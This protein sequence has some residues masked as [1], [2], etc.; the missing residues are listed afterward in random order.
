MSELIYIWI[1]AH[2][3]WVFFIKIKPLP[4]IGFFLMHGILFW[5]L[6]INQNNL[7]PLIGYYYRRDPMIMLILLWSGALIFLVSKICD[8]DLKKSRNSNKKPRS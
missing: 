1:V 2:L 4:I 3:F 7:E 8:A 5:V 6:L